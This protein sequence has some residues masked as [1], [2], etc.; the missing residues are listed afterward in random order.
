MPRDN[1]NDPT[2]Y[3]VVC[4]GDPDMDHPGC[5]LQFLS[6]EQYSAQLANPDRPWRCPSCGFGATVWDEECQETNRPEESSY[7][8]L[9]PLS[10]MG[11]ESLEALGIPIEAAGVTS[12]QAEDEEGE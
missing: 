8:R 7:Q 5:G 10:E 3:A 12:R 6:E 1:T 4:F 11:K 9:I 2:P